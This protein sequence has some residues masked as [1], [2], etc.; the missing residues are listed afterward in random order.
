MKGLPGKKKKTKTKQENGKKKTPQKHTY[1]QLMAPPFEREEDHRLTD[2]EI[3]KVD[4]TFCKV[5]GPCAHLQCEGN[6]AG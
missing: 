3:I 1:P 2:A 6:H 4:T 5:I